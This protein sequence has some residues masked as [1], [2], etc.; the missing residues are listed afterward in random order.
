MIPWQFLSLLIAVITLVLWMSRVRLK[1]AIN[2]P[3]SIVWTRLPG[4]DFQ[5]SDKFSMPSEPHRRLN[6][7]KFERAPTIAARSN[8]DV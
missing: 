8:I 7:G 2:A 4:D 1:W 5:M 6:L 3:L